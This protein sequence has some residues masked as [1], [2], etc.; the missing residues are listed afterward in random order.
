MH[1]RGVVDHQGLGN[2]REKRRKLLPNS[3]KCEL[4]Q[5]R[6][7]KIKFF[8]SMSYG[9]DQ[10]VLIAITL[11]LF[12]GVGHA[13]E[14]NYNYINF[15]GAKVSLKL[16]IRD[17]YLAHSNQDWH[18]LLGHSMDTNEDYL[19]YTK[20][21]FAKEEFPLR[22][23]FEIF[24]QNLAT[25]DD[26]YFINTVVSFVQTLPYKIPPT[27]YKG[28]NTSGILAPALCLAEGYGD[29]DTKSLLLA[30]ILAHKFDLIFLAGDHH[31]FIGIAYTPR[32]TDHFVTIDRVEYVLCEL[33]SRWP[34]GKLP[35]SSIHEINK[36]KYSYI[37]L[38]YKS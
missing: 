32:L 4:N 5:F 22:F 26:E 10:F 9:S 23:L 27:E 37:K 1:L 7:V 24:D 25:V 14:V 12:L 19:E 13:K 3:R 38:G 2:Q 16:D 15:D 20:M 29:C 17:S 31:A 6:G 33:T 28:K 36:K 8:G 34:L 11:L 30:C 35:N 18:E 21:L